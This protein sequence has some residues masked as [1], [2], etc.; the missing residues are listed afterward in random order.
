MNPDIKRYLDDHAATYTPQ[1]LRKGLLEAGHDP[2]AVDA[3]IREWQVGRNGG[4]G[5]GDPRTFGRWAMLLHLGALVATFGV[6]VL[7][8]GPAQ[9]GVVLV[10]VGVLAV[11]MLIGWDISSMIGR[12]LL[13]GGTTVAL[14]VPGISALLLGGSCPARIPEHPDRPAVRRSRS[15]S[16]HGRGR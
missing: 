5:P 16:P 15:R 9:A 6:L 2:V 4:S 10:G 8:K 13:G 12:S 7:L 14:I 3:A 1:A 11:A